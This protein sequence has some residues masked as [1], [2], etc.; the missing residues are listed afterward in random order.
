M[1][2]LDSELYSEWEARRIS[3]FSSRCANGRIRFHYSA[4]S[5]ATVLITRLRI[6]NILSLHDLLQLDVPNEITMIKK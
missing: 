4:T 5:E 1:R 3:F 2:Q 6:C